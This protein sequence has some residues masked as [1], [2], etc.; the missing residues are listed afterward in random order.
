VQLV[1]LTFLALS[2]FREKQVLQPETSA[3]TAG[4]IDK[5]MRQALGSIGDDVQRLQKRLAE[6]PDE[7]KKATPAA[8]QNPALTNAEKTKWSDAVAAAVL[9]KLK[10]ELKATP[11]VVDREAEK[12]ALRTALAEALRNQALPGRAD[13]EALRTQTQAIQKRLDV[14]IK[15]RDS[16][17]EQLD[18]L[19]L[20]THSH[21]LQVNEYI[22][23]YQRL[24]AGLPR[25]PAERYRLGFYVA[26]TGRL[27]SKV[28]L[29]DG[30]I[31]EKSYQVLASSGNETE[32]LEEIGS[33]LLDE[34]DPDR[35][36]RRCL[37]VASVQCEPPR[38]DADGWKQLRQI[39]VVLIQ[40]DRKNGETASMARWLEFCA[41]HGGGLTLL[42]ATE[43]AEPRKQAEQLYELLHRL[44]HPQSR[45]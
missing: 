17:S 32:R 10:P 20:A 21:R 36:N 2:Y 39:D 7:I 1:I 44:A 13:L 38:L 40:R 3:I 12:Q 4:E 35:P 29:K 23:A 6:L 42:A 31:G 30:K 16:P 33:K 26:V 5:G 41:A 37:V 8:P 15:E 9:E 18:V 25:D 27:D 34:F 19:V 43:P 45:R 28:G 22:E 11:Q 14:L 24:I